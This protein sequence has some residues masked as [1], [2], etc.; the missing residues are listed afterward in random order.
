MKPIREEPV[1]IT[2]ERR[3]EIQAEI[4]KKQAELDK[5]QAELNK[6]RLPSEWVLSN[7]LSLSPVVEQRRQIEE[8]I[9]WLKR[10]LSWSDLVYSPKLSGKIDDWVQKEWPALL[11]ADSSSVDPIWDKGYSQGYTDGRAFERRQRQSEGGRKKSDKY[12]A[13][14]KK[15]AIAQAKRLWKGEP[16]ARMGEVVNSIF[17]NLQ[18]KDPENKPPQ[19]GTI[20]KWLKVAEKN[21]ELTIPVAASR[22]GATKKDS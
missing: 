22:P 4:D 14:P 17:L 16:D 10:D 18:H 19:P 7:G 21:R 2:W 12:Y 15:Y 6:L 3:P 1:L 5:L 11:D 9:Y 20:K 8:E 13:E